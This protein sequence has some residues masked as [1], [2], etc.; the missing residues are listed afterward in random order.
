MTKSKI[1]DMGIK[2]KIAT[3]VF[4][5]E[6]TDKSKDG[7]VEPMQPESI[8]P[9]QRIIITAVIAAICIVP[10]VINLINQANR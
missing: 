2:D 3:K 9:V 1:K 4:S 6:G 5:D 8:L 7:V 10:F